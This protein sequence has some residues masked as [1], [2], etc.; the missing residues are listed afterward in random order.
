MQ[1]YPIATAVKSGDSS[2]TVVSE[3]KRGTSFPT[4]TETLTSTAVV[5]SYMEAALGSTSDGSGSFVLC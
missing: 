3:F 1:L 5:F 4:T 2:P